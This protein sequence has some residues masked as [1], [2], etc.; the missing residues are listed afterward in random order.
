MANGKKRRKA[1]NGGKS[2][3]NWEREGGKAGREKGE[4]KKA[5]EGSSEDVL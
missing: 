4:S 1:S 3:D 5:I 2:T